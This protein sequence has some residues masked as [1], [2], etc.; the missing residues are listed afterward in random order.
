MT[1]FSV[2]GIGGIKSVL[3]LRIRALIGALTNSSIVSTHTSC[4]LVSRSLN[5]VWIPFFLGILMVRDFLHGMTEP[6][7]FVLRTQVRQD[8]S[9]YLS[10]KKEFQ[11][12]SLS[13]GNRSTSYSRN[14]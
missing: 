12:S 13:I 6:P 10:L 2:I 14:V 11:A 1:R 9:L 8:A 5:T 7:V 4:G 3:R